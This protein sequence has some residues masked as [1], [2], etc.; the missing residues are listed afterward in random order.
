M[1]GNPAQGTRAAFDL[2][3]FP[4]CL[5]WLIISSENFLAWQFITLHERVADN[6]VK[7]LN[8]MSRDS[9]IP[10]AVYGSKLCRFTYPIFL[11]KLCIHAVK[12]ALHP[13][14]VGRLHITEELRVTCWVHLQTISQVRRKGYSSTITDLLFSI[15]VPDEFSEARRYAWS[16]VGFVCSPGSGGASRGI[17]KTWENRWMEGK[18]SLSS[19]ALCVWMQMEMAHLKEGWLKVKLSSFS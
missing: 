7:S 1:L 5:P 18:Y 12:T 17:S 19:G 9:A 3:Y 15:L 13:L 10:H 11:S 4:T 14:V 16:S 8:N 6:P 2:L